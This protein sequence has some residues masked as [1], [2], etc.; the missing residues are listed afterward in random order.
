MKIIITRPRMDAAPLAETLRIKGHQPVIAPLIEIVPRA[1]V[2]VPNLPYQALCVTSA[3]GIRCLEAEVS[4]D[5]PVYAVGAQSAYA[6][7]ACG[8][9]HVEAHGGDVIGLTTFL[10]R[11]LDPAK[12]PLLYISGAETSGDLQ[13]QLQK[14]GFTV[15]RVITYDAV[16]QKL[17]AI[18][19]EIAGADGVMLYSPRSAKLWR[20]ELFRLNLGEQGGRLMHY[21]LSPQIAAQLAENWPRKIAASPVESDLIGLLD[22]ATKAE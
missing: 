17:D 16:P 4:R 22:L 2:V 9:V 20:A 5:L 10:T 6:A 12:G 21:C 7:E 15:S 1:Q 13:G 19:G 18:R 3:N 14:A 8:F 11:K